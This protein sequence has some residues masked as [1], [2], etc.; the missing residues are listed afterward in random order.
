MNEKGPDCGYDKRYISVVICD[1]D[2][3]QP[4][5]N[6]WWQHSNCRSDAF[7]LTTMNPC[8]STFIVRSSPF[9]QYISF[10]TEETFGHGGNQIC[11]EITRHNAS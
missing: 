1:R 2:T 6:S 7:N 8:F 10:I 4:L 5:T 9:Q 11:E 3:P